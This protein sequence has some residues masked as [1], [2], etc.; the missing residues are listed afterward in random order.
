MLPQPL[1]VLMLSI[2]YCYHHYHHPHYYYYYH[3]HH[4]HHHFLGRCLCPGKLFFI[5]YIFL[6]LATY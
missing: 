2:N 5:H 3:H 1:L 6:Q 4:H